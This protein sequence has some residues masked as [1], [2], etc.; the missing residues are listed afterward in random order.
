MHRVFEPAIALLVTLAALVLIGSS[1]A[2]ERDPLLAPAGR[3]PDPGVSDPPAVQQNAMLCLHAYA[4]RQAGVQ[5][6]HLVA[7]LVRSASI[8]TLW[9]RSCRSFSHTPCGH[10]FTSAFRAVNYLA[11]AA[12]SVGE[13]LAWGEGLSGSPRSIFVA[14]LN[15][16]EHRRNIVDSNWREVGLIRTRASRLFEHANGTLWVVEFGRQGAVS[17]ESIESCRTLGPSACR[18]RSAR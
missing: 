18:R 7:Q 4:R 17:A 15:S 8:K 6:V 14:W 2:G 9:I 11:D 13:N 16:P 1:H 12:W 10:S 5:P 3:C